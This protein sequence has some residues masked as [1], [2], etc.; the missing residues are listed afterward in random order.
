VEREGGKKR[1]IC[2]QVLPQSLL[3]PEKIRLEETLLA[4]EGGLLRQNGIKRT[5]AIC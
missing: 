5:K 3:Y 1:A 4:L 2:R